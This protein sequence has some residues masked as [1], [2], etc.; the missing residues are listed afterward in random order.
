MKRAKMRTLNI[1][2][3]FYKH[4]DFGTFLVLKSIKTKFFR[5][6]IYIMH[7]L[8]VGI[9]FLYLKQLLINFYPMFADLA[10]L[11]NIIIVIAVTMTS[12]IISYEFILDRDL[13]AEY[14]LKKENKR[15][16]K[17]HKLQWWRLRN[18]NL[19]FRIV[20][21]ILIYV[22]LQQ[23]INA[24]VAAALIDSSIS[25]ISIANEYTFYMNIFSMIFITLTMLIEYRTNTLIR[26]SKT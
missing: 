17:I 22:L 7:I 13:A 1:A 9:G 23:F 3:F 25:F 2:L 6:L 20:F 24:S 16:K 18:M 10:F 12:T 26:G 19:F 4:F 11:L 14:Q 5:I 15:Y 21:Y 8:V